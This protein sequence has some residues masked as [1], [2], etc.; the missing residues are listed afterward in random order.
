MGDVPSDRLQTILADFDATS[1]IAGCQSICQD[2]SAC[3][4]ACRS[5]AAAAD[6]LAVSGR[7]Q[8]ALK[9]ASHL[10]D[11]AVAS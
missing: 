1:T 8:S 11:D 10:L 7:I 4:H 5:L 6:I 2:E 9:I 3:R